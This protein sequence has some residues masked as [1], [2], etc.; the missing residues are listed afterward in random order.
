MFPEEYKKIFKDDSK[1]I[2][3]KIQSYFED[4]M[5]DSFYDGITQ[6]INEVHNK[7]LKDCE[8]YKL[9]LKLKAQFESN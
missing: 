1:I 8:D 5:S 4:N 6:V 7:R 9:Y 2:I 3:E